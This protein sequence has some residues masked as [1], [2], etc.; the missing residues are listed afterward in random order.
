VWYEAF[1]AIIFN[2]AAIWDMA[3]SS[4]VKRCQRFGKISYVLKMEAK[5]S[6]ETSVQVYH[7]I[8]RHIL[9]D[10][11]VSTFLHLQHNC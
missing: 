10:H 11:S 5:V 8:W 9:N 6:F 4:W 7:P 2:M 3:T 1:A